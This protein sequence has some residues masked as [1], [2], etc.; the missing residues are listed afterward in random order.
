MIK[1]DLFQIFIN[2]IELA[3]NQSTTYYPANVGG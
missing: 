3:F 1:I 2:F